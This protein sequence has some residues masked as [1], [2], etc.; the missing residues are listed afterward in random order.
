LAERP[1]RGLTKLIGIASITSTSA[2]IGMPMRHSS[3]PRFCRVRFV[4]SARVGR[5]FSVGATSLLSLVSMRAA[6]LS[7]SVSRYSGSPGAPS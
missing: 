3:S 7:N 5:F 2:E 4:I 1:A 6:Y